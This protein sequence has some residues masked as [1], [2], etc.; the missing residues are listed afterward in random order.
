MGP[1]RGDGN[2]RTFF[3]KRFSNLVEKMGPLRGDGNISCMFVKHVFMVEKMGPLRGD[4][5]THE[6]ALVKM[7]HYSREDGS[8][9]WGRK[10]C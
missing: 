7:L 5:N 9:S 10:L 6:T 2:K 8:P 1:L 3:S 4:G